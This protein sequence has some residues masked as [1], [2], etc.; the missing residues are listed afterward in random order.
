MKATSRIT[1]SDQPDHKVPGASP[2]A[3]GPAATTADQGNLTDPGSLDDFIRYDGAGRQKRTR[4]GI[5]LP[6]IDG[7]RL[8]DLI[9][10]A[11]FL[12]VS[13]AT[14]NQN[15]YIRH[16]AGYPRPLGLDG[17]GSTIAASLLTEQPELRAALEEL[18]WRSGGQGAPLRL[19]RLTELEAFR[20]NRNRQASR[21]SGK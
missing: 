15:V 6:T 13:Q 4:Q 18:L 8:Y 16:T 3:T 14:I 20:A 19:W 2:A 17:N 21:K 1:F 7:D 12:G 11:E 9:A 5:V 10:A